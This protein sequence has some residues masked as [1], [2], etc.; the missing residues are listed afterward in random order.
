[1]EIICAG[2]SKTSSK[3]C[4][5]C[6]RTLGY[7]VADYFETCQFLSDIWL[8]YLEG[9]CSIHKVIDEYKKYGFQAN[10]DFPG[11]MYWE[12]LYHASPNAKVII[13]IR[14]NAEVWHQSQFNFMRQEFQR[15]GN[16][17][18]WL[19]Q[20]FTNFGWTSPR[21]NN[22]RKI[23][24]IV[25]NEK[26]FRTNE[27]VKWSPAD[28]KMFTWQQQLEYMKPYWEA[29][30]DKYEAQIRRVKKVV[31]EDRL[32]VWNIKEGWEPL[33]KFL[34]KPVPDFPIPE[35]EGK[36]EMDQELFNHE[37]EL[38]EKE[39]EIKALQDQKDQL[40]KQRQA[41]A[42][43]EAIVISEQIDE[44]LKK[45][46]EIEA[47]AA[48][49]CAYGKEVVGLIAS[50]EIN[51]KI[52]EFETRNFARGV[53]FHKDFKPEGNFMDDVAMIELERDFQLTEKLQ[54]AC[55][56]ETDVDY[57]GMQCFIALV[58]RLLLEKQE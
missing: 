35:T 40:I 14:D 54:P 45:K 34:G 55:L 16:P 23:F 1:M 6:L 11:N 43:V 8:D 28:W 26:F 15:L 5:S 27:P 7:K 58:F 30:K 41:D 18:F 49:S 48:A 19:Y 36:P 25:S 10:Q 52:E 32:L 12:E 42:E 39:Q 22:I 56:P 2:F 33:C 31:P 17:G 46:K 53:Y 3:S 47:Q 57:T 37:T 44:L 38:M 13:T 21:M 24:Q 9:R 51:G 50:D 20:R 4:S 29:E